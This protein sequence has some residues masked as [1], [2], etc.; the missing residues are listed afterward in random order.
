MNKIS[1]LILLIFFSLFNGEK[2]YSQNTDKLKWWQDGKF[3]LFLHWGL[4]SIG[5]WNEKPQKGNEHFMFVERIP[6]Q[7]YAKIGASF[8]P[9]HFNADRWVQTAK[10]AGMKYIV[11]TA[12]HHD[13]FAMFN[14]PSDTYNIVKATPYHHDPMLDLAT[15]C[16][17]YGVKLCF[18]Y[19][20]GRDWASP[21]ASWTKEGSKAGNTWDFP[22]EQVK[23]NNKYIELKVKPQLKELLIQY[24]PVG[25]IWFD[26]PEGTTPTQ[27]ESLRK[28]I[29]SLQPN[30]IINS[31]VG[32]GFGDYAVS[33]QKIIAGAETKPWESCITMS[34]KWGFSKFDK[35][36]KSPELLVRNLVEIVCKGGN[37]LLNVGPDSLGDFPEQSTQNLQA[38]GKWMKTNSEA[39]YGTQPW[40]TVSEFA[41]KPK[42]DAVEVM[43]KSSN[44]FTSKKITS[45]L[46][47]NQKENTIYVF[48]RSWNQTSISSK[49][50]AQLKNINQIQL[51]GNK[52]KIKW[53]LQNEQLVIHM[54]NQ[55][56]SEIPVYVF[57]ISLKK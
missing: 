33:E 47:F 45:D 46:Y 9:L 14:S 21:D 34:G 53:E 39:I 32:N 41:T 42:E 38:I 19:S 40:T 44:D 52:H 23:D 1:I 3:G 15:A 48:A 13:G 26:T 55:T 5:Q 18:Y 30:C 37:L 10:D 57:K 49:T 2:T 51:V 25:A 50:L 17:K 36:W 8:N 31:R 24:G 35:A 43:G 7:E 11:I 6:L 12:K 27:S 56:T 29:L 4:Y 22:N 54:P 20:L 16:K 28:L